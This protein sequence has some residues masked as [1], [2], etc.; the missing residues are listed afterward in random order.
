MEAT[1]ELFALGRLS[2]ALR[3]WARFVDG[4][5]ELP[6]AVNLRTC[7]EGMLESKGS[8]GEWRPWRT[9]RLRSRP[10]CVSRAIYLSPYPLVMCVM[11]SVLDWIMRKGMTGFLISQ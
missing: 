2:N 11:I 5:G 1:N 3:M 10:W 8:I 6:R 7:P 4:R 9:S